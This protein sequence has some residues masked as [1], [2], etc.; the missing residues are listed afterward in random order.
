M[1][2]EL[3]LQTG[4]FYCVKNNKNKKLSPADLIKKECYT[5]CECEG[6]YISCKYLDYRINQKE[7]N[8]K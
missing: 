7:E 3:K 2:L 4:D 5:K 1:T 8:L 6:D